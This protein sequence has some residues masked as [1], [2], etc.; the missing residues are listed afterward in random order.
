MAIGYS[1]RKANIRKQ[2]IKILL[3]CEGQ[4]TERIYFGRYRARNNGLEI[5]TPKTNVTDPKNLVKFA[6][7]QIKKY[8]ID[9]QYGDQV[10]CVFDADKNTL[11]N[12]S[13]AN[14]LAQKNNINL[15]LSNPC[16]ELWY[17][18][19][20]IY[21]DQKISTVDLLETLTKYILNYTKSKDYFDNLA[22]NRNNA[23]KNA[24]RLNKKHSDLGIE[25]LSLASNPST[26]VVQIVQNILEIFSKNKNSL[27]E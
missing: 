7:S 19:H 21:Y 15:C 10:W 2:I 13:D 20:Y 14:K 22:N 25:L 11:Q 1:S 26:L 18:L 23:I 16:F 8:G 3:I 4:K 12:I 5:L 24:I 17:L 6:L 27:I 9:F